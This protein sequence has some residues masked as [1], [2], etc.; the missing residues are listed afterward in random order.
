MISW[1]KRKWAQRKYRKLVNRCLA[2]KDPH[3]Y[4]MGGW[5][6]NHIGWL[7]RDNWEGGRVYGHK[8]RRPNVGDVVEINMEGGDTMLGRFIEVEYCRDPR[9]M[10]FGTLHFVGYEEKKDE[11]V[12]CARCKKEWVAEHWKQESCPGCAFNRIMDR[13]A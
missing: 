12:R 7:D 6:G 11:F 9:D 10:F 3:V 1:I 8:P 13:E 5:W 2:V 4:A